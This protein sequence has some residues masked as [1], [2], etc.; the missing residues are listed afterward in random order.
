MNNL[1][2]IL[3]TFKKRLEAAIDDW[4]KMHMLNAPEKKEVE[5]PEVQPG[6]EYVISFEDDSDLEAGYAELR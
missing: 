2:T 4:M 6:E 1:T 3:T 5:Q